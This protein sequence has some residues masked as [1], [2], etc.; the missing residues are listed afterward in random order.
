MNIILYNNDSNL[1]VRYTQPPT[2]YAEIDTVRVYVQ[3]NTETSQPIAVPT[4]LRLEYSE[5]PDEGMPL[6]LIENISLK[7]DDSLTLE[8]YFGFVPKVGDAFPAKNYTCTLIVNGAK[9]NVGEFIFANN[10]MI[11]QHNALM[12]KDK[13]IT[14][15][16]KEV[17][18]VAEDHLSQEITFLIKEKYDGISFLDETKKVYVD[19]I[20]VGYAPQAGE[21]SFLS[22]N[23][24]VRS[25]APNTTDGDNWIYLRW[26]VPNTATRKAGKLSFA[27]A[28]LGSDYVWQT[29]PAS[30]TVYPNIGFRGTEEPFIPSEPES[31]EA[32][33]ELEERI[34]T[35]E[36]NYLSMTGAGNE[37]GLVSSADDGDDEILLGGGSA[38]G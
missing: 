28:V 33:T 22:D 14:V 38:N 21:P 18:L 9:Y 36:E 34:S 35:I 13:T 32:L 4:E 19:Y 17:M 27:L 29:Q 1:A 2:E 6:Y 24:I 3:K 10:S 37:Y 12:I 23:H 26:R 15:V 11:D 30:L 31:D 7:Q 5:E 20:P 16:N 25:Y 8:K